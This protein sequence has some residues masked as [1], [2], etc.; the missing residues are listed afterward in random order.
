MTSGLNPYYF[1]GAQSKLL[2]ISQ[3]CNIF[4]FFSIFC[5]DDL[6]SYII[7]KSGP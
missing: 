5:S 7:V 2:R 1:F 3:A 4:R 6:G